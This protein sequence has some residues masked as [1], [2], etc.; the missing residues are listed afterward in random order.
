MANVFYPLEVKAHLDFS[1]SLQKW[2][3][4]ILQRILLMNQQNSAV[5]H[6]LDNFFGAVALGGNA[7]FP[8]YAAYSLFSTLGLE[9]SPEKTFWNCTQLG[10][11]G[12]VIDTKLQTASISAER[13]RKMIQLC[14]G[15]LECGHSNLL[16]MQQITG[17]LQLITQIAPHGKVFLCRLYDTLAPRTRNPL[18][19][20]HI[21]QPAKEEPCWWIQTLESWDGI[22]LLQPSPL[23]SVHM[24][25]GASKLGPGAHIG[26]M[27]NPT[28]VWAKEVSKRH[29]KKDI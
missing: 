15:L 18:L 21:Q 9:G 5:T 6:Y 14:Q 12:I 17:Y 10:I 4:W 26:L 25:S 2:V 16:D 7:F 24:W 22:T 11:L 28:A 8:V 3:H 19:H 20:Q 29:C 1:I 13:Q 23:H 27:S